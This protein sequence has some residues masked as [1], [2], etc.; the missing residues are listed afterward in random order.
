MFTNVK[1]R[2]GKAGAGN[3][4][5]DQIASAQLNGG[6]LLRPVLIYVRRDVFAATQIALAWLVCLNRKLLLLRNK[7][8]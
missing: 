5:D 2:V 3:K 4:R 7:R 1:F 8:T 6:F